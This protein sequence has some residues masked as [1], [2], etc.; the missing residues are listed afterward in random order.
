MNDQLSASLGKFLGN[1]PVSSYTQYVHNTA[2]K[3]DHALTVAKECLTKHRFSYERQYNKS[4]RSHNFR[5]GS[6]VLIK[7][8][9]LS[10]AR[11]NIVSSLAKKWDG[12][13]EIVKKINQNVFDVKNLENNKIVRINVDQLKTF[14]NRPAFVD[15][16]KLVLPEQE[17]NPSCSG[18]SA[19]RHYDFRHYK[20]S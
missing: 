8:V 13:Y 4:R 7:N 15:K 19:K 3:F 10:D 6:I 14:Y 17:R 18:P 20:E 1:E 16:V 12:P 11:K 9:T 5:V 2:L